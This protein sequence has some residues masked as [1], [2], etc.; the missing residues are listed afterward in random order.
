M[1]RPREFDRSKALRQA[2]EAFWELGY[3]NTSTAVL[4]NRLDIGRSSLYAAFGTK[5]E[6]YAEAMDSYI[7]DLRVRVIERLRAEG[8]A[9]TVL[10]D[11]FLGVADRGDPGSE[12]RRC[13]MIV[14]ACLSGNDQPPEIKSRIKKTVA[15]LDDAFHSLLKRARDQGT[16]QNGGK[17]RDTARFLTTTFQSLS[18]AAH[19]GRSQRELREIVRRAL[20][21]L[22]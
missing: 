2:M 18:V 13:C 8:P 21:G 17:L 1:A 9:M 3:E 19:A 4:V 11:F 5:E 22:E 20:A 16:L 15:E 12:R 6:L 7:E 14:R 10:Q